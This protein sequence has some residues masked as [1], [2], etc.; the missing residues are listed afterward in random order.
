MGGIGELPTARS[1]S[2]RCRRVATEPRLPPGTRGMGYSPHDR[3]RPRRRRANAVGRVRGDGL[4]TSGTNSNIPFF[5]LS[6]PHRLAARADSIPTAQGTTPSTRRRRASTRCAS[7]RGG[8]RKGIWVRRE[9]GRE[10]PHMN[11]PKAAELARGRRE[12]RGGAAGAPRPIREHL[13][14]I[15]PRRSSPRPRSCDTWDLR[16]GQ[17]WERALT[18]THLQWIRSPRGQFPRTPSLPPCRENDS[19]SAVQWFMPHPMPLHLRRP[20]LHIAIADAPRLQRPLHAHIAHSP[21]L[22]PQEMWNPSVRRTLELPQGANVPYDPNASYE[23]PPP[24]ANRA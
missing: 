3:R 4:G 1:L 11:L 22:A 16:A 8:G 18:G 9:G 19:R 6:F 23:P 12:G 20:S 21:R 7:R 10:P 14:P 24:K 5:P 17:R 15:A 2:R 13:P